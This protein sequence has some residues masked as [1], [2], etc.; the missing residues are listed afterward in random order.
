MEVPPPTNKHFLTESNIL[1][2]VSSKNYTVDETTGDDVNF[3]TLNE[4]KNY[5]ST[6]KNVATFDSTISNNQYITS[7]DIT[8]N[9]RSF[10]FNLTYT[11]VYGSNC[12]TSQPTG[13]TGTAQP[14]TFETTY[15]S[16]ST[17]YTFYCWKQS[18]SCTS[19]SVLTTD[20]C[21]TNQTIM[22][23]TSHNYSFVKLTVSITDTTN[24]SS[25][26]LSISF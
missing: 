5:N 15:T 18:S 24:T 1:Y 11:L 7:S 10:T 26:S 13:F 8:L 20:N 17:S 2:I 4:A 22:T 12:Q 16:T 23:N 14:G 19:V 6:I 3:L 9:T 21:E 25:C